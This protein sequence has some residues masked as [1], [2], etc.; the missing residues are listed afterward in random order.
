[1]LKHSQ[2]VINVNDLQKA[3]LNKRAECDVEGDISDK[4]PKVN[5]SAK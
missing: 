1:M 2:E 3:D 5:W 4:L